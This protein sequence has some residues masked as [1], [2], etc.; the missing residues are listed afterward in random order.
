M[1]V[2]HFL[3]DLLYIKNKN[4]LDAYQYRKSTTGGNK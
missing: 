4:E 1:K 3:N 2:V